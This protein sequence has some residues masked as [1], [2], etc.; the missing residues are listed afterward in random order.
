MN[1]LLVLIVIVALVAVVRAWLRCRADERMRRDPPAR[2]VFEIQLPRAVDDSPQRMLSFLRTAY[3]ATD[4]D[5]RDRRDGRAQLDLWF[6]VERKVGEASP[7]LSGL[8][9]SCDPEKAQL[10]R[11][12]LANAFGTDA[13][14]V[15]RPSDDGCELAKRGRRRVDATPN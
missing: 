9:V 4:G 14:I 13:T 11:S 15:D 5:R 6:L 2:T 3:P 12:A 10:V 7:S 8:R 1:Q